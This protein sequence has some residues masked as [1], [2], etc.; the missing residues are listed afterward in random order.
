MTCGV[1]L[2]VREPTIVFLKS[3]NC[4]TKQFSGFSQLKPYNNFS[5][6]QLNQTHA[7]R[8]AILL[9][10]FPVDNTSGGP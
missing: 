10:H 6:P 8:P 4:S 1:Y 2:E 5:Q 3:H 7:T 9:Y